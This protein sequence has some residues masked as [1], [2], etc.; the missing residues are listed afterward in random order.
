MNSIFAYGGV[1]AM[2]G[3]ASGGNVPVASTVYLEFVPSPGYTLSFLRGG[4]LAP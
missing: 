3:F 4:Q 2:V 1:F